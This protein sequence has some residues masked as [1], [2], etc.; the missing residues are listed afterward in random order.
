M[1]SLPLLGIAETS[2]A[3]IGVVSVSKN[4]SDVQNLLAKS[5]LQSPCYQVLK[6]F[7]LRTFSL[8]GIVYLA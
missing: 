7:P 5:H 2:L 8:T 6:T 4:H 1:S 3:L